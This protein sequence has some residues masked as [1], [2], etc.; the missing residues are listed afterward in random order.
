MQQK[1]SLI[2]QYSVLLY[3]CRVPIMFFTAQQQC[4]FSLPPD[5]SNAH[6]SQYQA[7]QLPTTY[8]SLIFQSDAC[9]FVRH[10]YND[11]G[12][13][14]IPCSDK[15]ILLAFLGSSCSVPMGSSSV[16]QP[17]RSAVWTPRYMNQQDILI[18]SL[19]CTKNIM[20]PM[21]PFVLF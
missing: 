8:P 18:Q 16:L 9:W 10:P 21:L 20:R 11:V 19:K 2:Q 1:G 15:S 5:Q 7:I 3:Q 6:Y 12:C 13:T 17:F 4:F 14:N